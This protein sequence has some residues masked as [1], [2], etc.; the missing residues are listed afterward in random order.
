MP[1]C[2][3]RTGK[4]EPVEISTKGNEEW[5]MASRDYKCLSDESIFWIHNSDARGMEELE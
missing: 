4:G 3:G 1:D 2:G 5:I